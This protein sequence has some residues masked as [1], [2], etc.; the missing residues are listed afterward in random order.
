MSPPAELA[1]PA[2]DG[3]VPFAEG[4]VGC[5]DGDVPFVEGG[6]GSGDGDFGSPIVKPT[7]PS[8]ARR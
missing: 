8:G 3:D 6:V 4:D 1:Q 7:C 2:T 5:A